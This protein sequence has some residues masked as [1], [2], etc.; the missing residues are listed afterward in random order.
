MLRCCLN[1]VSVHSIST[2]VFRAPAE[3]S[4]LSRYPSRCSLSRCLA[5][6]TPPDTGTSQARSAGHLSRASL[7]ETSTSPTESSRRPA[8]SRGHRYL[9]LPP[10][11]PNLHV[12]PYCVCLWHIADIRRRPPEVSF[13]TQTE[14]LGLNSC[15]WRNGFSRGACIKPGQR[16]SMDYWHAA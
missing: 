8:T 4:A 5:P 13:L 2:E 3:A 9:R 12:D 7:F 16:L 6:P 14:M 10:A 11:P 15:K 1:A